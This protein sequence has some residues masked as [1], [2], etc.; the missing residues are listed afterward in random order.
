[1]VAYSLARANHAR[2]PRIS[3]FQ[4]AGGRRVI[5]FDT[6][7][8]PSFSANARSASPSDANAAFLVVP[9]RVALWTVCYREMYGV[10]PPQAE[11]RGTV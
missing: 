2:S 4:P 7:R 8:R 5:Q 3:A 1:M 6:T 10:E 9:E 11:K